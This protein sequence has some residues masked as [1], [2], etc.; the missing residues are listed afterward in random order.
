M[1]WYTLAKKKKR[2]QPKEKMIPPFARS[3]AY[4]QTG[5]WWIIDGTAFFADAEIG[6]YNHSG[7]VIE[8]ILSYHDIPD[9]IDLNKETEESLALKGLNQEEIDAVLD[10]TDPREYGLKHL[11][12]KRVKMNN[13]DTYTLVEQ[14]LKEIANGLFDAN[15]ALEDD[16]ETPFNIWVDSTK[17]FYEMVPYSVIR[18]GNPSALR[19]YASGAAQYASKKGWYKRAQ[20]VLFIDP[21]DM[22]KIISLVDKIKKGNREWTDE[23]LQ[24]QQNHRELIEGILQGKVFVDD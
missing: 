4:A 12:W 20:S 3:M 11:G 14:D 5:E 9:T 15:N 10:K 17:V 7:M 13:I 16:S 1:N 19:I 24:V 22:K 23:E 8:H 21:E 18:D 2:R 6:D